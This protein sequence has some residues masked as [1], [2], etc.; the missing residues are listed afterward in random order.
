MSAETMAATY[1]NLPRFREICE[2]VDPEGLLGS[3]MARR[4]ELRS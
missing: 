4:L 1:P 2:R 3:D